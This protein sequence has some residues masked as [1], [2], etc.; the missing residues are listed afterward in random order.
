VGQAFSLQV[1]KIDTCCGHP[2]DVACAAQLLT[3]AQPLIVDL[4]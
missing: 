4:R 3:Q 2:L 1:R